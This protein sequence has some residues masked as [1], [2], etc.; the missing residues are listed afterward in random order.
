MPVL[1]APFGK[2]LDLFATLLL[3]ITIDHQKSHMFVVGTSDSCIL[4]V[5]VKCFN[6]YYYIHTFFS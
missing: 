1:L 3:L 2:Q 5:F 4:S 6:T